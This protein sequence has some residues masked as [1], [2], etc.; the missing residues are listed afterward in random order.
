[1]KKAL[2]IVLYI[3]GGVFGLVAVACSAFWL[4]LVWH[5]WPRS[6]EIDDSEFHSAAVQ[7]LEGLACGSTPPG[8]RITSYYRKNNFN[9]G[10]EL[11]RLEPDSISAVSELVARLRLM[12]GIPHQHVPRFGGMVDDKPD[13]VLRPQTN[14][15][16]LFV[17][18]EKQEAAVYGGCKHG[19]FYLWSLD[20]QVFFLYHIIT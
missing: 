14:M 1:M 8:I 16:W 3:V 11:W 15:K 20:G 5:T 2:R 7:P 9:D 13:W 18:D 10:D 6:Y 17:D 19:I 4:M 12:P